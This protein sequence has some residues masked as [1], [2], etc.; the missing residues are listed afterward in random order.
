ADTL[1]VENVAVAFVMGLNEGEFPAAG[2]DAGL[3][4]SDEK[5]QLR[6]MGL[7]LD[8][9][10]EVQAANE[11]FYVLRAMSK[12]S[13]RLFVSTAR[14]DSEGKLKSPSLPYVRL[15]TILPHL[16]ACTR[17]FDLSM[18]SPPSDVYDMTYASTTDEGDDESDAPQSE[19]DRYQPVEPSEHDVA[20][21]V[22]ARLL[23]KDLY[24]T[25][26]KIDRF[27]GC[28]YSFYCTHFLN[29][30]ERE[31]ARV[32]AS[33][34][35][36]F[37]H[38]LFEEF[39][40][41]CIAED[42]SFSLPEDSEVEG[43][44]DKIVNKFILS[45]GD[46]AMSD[47]RTLHVF[48]RLRGLALILLR[49]ILHELKHSAFRPVA[50]EEHIGEGAS[51]PCYEIELTDGHRILL[52]GT[53]DRVDCYRQGEDVYLR[54]VDYKT[55]TKE[56]SLKDIARGANMQLLIYLFSLCRPAHTHPAGAMYVATNHG[57]SK[58]EA[59]RSGLLLS[60]HTIL[61]AMNDEWDKKYLA[62][63][64]KTK[65]NEISGKAQISAEAL[66]QLERDIRDTL[67]TIGE[68]MIHGRA[69]RT[70]SK[71]ACRYCSMRAGCPVADHSK[72]SF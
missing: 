34:R 70:P 33:D 8:K 15:A 40:R 13:E 4:S 60:D 71:D 25:Q 32:D 52:S 16:K 36:T 6:E 72:G 63:I 14:A 50:F 7:T 61:S 38:H 67:G 31:P 35:G 44:C 54:V 45:L 62:G 22:T 11:L 56:F 64:S 21:E 12:P 53:V 24:L 28:P 19:E 43:I 57:D 49:D 27:V 3:L 30:R 26:S 9:D 58:P 29:L 23:G 51:V 39:L 42:G 65:N 41:G 69:A 46:T 2:R 55:G 68:D 20:P 37:I 17:T 59:H 10:D 47:L 66:D 5:Q 1:R 18:I 48:R